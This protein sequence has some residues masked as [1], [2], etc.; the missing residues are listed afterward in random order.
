[1]GEQMVSGSDHLEL[2]RLVVEMAW[3]IDHGASDSVHELFV[4]EGVLDLGPAKVEGRL[5]IRD[6]GRERRTVSYTT[7]HVLSNMRFVADGSERAVGSSTQT[8]FLSDGT[9]ANPTMPLAVSEYH[10]RFVR[11]DQGWR[12]SSHTIEHVFLSA[13][14]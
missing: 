7:R 9:E 10:D 13:T 5:A 2:T 4:E 11:T 6:W 8:V 1:M 12:F 14:G 3:R